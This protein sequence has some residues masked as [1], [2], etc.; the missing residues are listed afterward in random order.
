MMRRLA[1]LAIFVASS[2]LAQSA[3]ESASK[4]PE[5]AGK[6]ESTNPPPELHAFI[7]AH[8]E[9]RTFTDDCVICERDGKALNCSTPAIAC[10]TGAPTCTSEIGGRS[11]APGDQL[12]PATKN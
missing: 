6:P 2:A 10:M 5:N 11:V 3:P 9:C 8:P 7:D 4:P 12:P 1:I